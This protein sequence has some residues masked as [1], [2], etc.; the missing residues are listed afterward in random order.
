MFD[1]GDCVYPEN[2]DVWTPISVVGAKKLKHIKLRSI[3][4]WKFENTL[5]V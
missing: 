2:V 5:A 1:E 3:Q 4:N